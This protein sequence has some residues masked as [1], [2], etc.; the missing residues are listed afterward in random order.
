M[1]GRAN[2]ICSCGHPR[3][4]HHHYR[5]GTDC[6]ICGSE[7]CPSFSR[8]HVPSVRA[9]P[10]PFDELTGVPDVPSDDSAERSRRPETDPA[11]NVR[12]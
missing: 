10:D 5:R 8:T 11:F 12:P 7:I 2:D 9:Q 4:G 1:R 6:G 3:E